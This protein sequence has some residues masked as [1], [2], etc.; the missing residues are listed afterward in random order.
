MSQIKITIQ[1]TGELVEFLQFFCKSSIQF[2]IENQEEFTDLL[3]KAIETAC[4]K[5]RWLK[6]SVFSDYLD[7]IISKY[8]NASVN[9]FI[10][11]VRDMSSDSYYSE[12]LIPSHA[13][14]YMCG[15]ENLNRYGELSRNDA[16][17]F[18]RKQ[19]HIKGNEAAD[20]YFY[21]IFNKNVSKLEKCDLMEEIDAVFVM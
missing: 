21:E 15:P 5:V 17:E 4:V 7:E 8:D 6:N 20:S 3:Y 14:K 19:I 2:T 13:F 18:I 9:E 12:K 1:T 11:R 10:Y 16:Y